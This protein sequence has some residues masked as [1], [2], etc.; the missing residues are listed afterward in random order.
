MIQVIPV[1]FLVA[2]FHDCARILDVDSIIMRDYHR[3]CL[4]IAEFV[5]RFTRFL[6]SELI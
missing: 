6:E 2:V 5:K 4:L 1:L 3:S